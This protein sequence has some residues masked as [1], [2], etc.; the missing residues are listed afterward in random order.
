MQL[1]DEL[2]YNILLQQPPGDMSSLMTFALRHLV[3]IKQTF[4]LS[5][6]AE[7]N[8]V[9]SDIGG[10]APPNAKSQIPS[11]TSA[12][13]STSAQINEGKKVGENNKN[14]TVEAK[15]ATS[16]TSARRKKRK[17]SKAKDA[18]RAS[19]APSVSSVASAS[20]KPLFTIEDVHIPEDLDDLIQGFLHEVFS[21]Q[22]EGGR[23]S[24]TDFAIEF[25]SQSLKSKGISISQIICSPKESLEGLKPEWN[26]GTKRTR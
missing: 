11:Q 3:Q 19:K 10:L 26:G 6:N 23:E 4:M 25:F 2:V 13:K 12:D 1:V 18:S 7:D 22:P 8:L 16:K 15:N 14:Q 21:R 17:T 24:L 5:T 20:S 9:P